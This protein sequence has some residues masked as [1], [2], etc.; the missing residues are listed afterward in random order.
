MRNSNNNKG[1]LESE[2]ER[3]REKE[4]KLG[5]MLSIIRVKFFVD[6]GTYYFFQLILLDEPLN[7]HPRCLHFQNFFK[8]IKYFKIKIRVIKRIFSC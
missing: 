8:I 5:I 6:N 3:E 1:A 2:R 7:K 4:E